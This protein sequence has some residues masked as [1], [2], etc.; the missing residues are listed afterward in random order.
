LINPRTPDLTIAPDPMRRPKVAPAGFGGDKEAARIRAP[1]SKSR[2][3]DPIFA[4]H[5]GQRLIQRI[6]CI[7]RQRTAN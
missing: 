3:S 7:T 4:D 1:Q 6:F 5:N 2:R